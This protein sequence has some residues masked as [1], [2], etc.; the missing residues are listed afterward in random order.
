[1]VSRGHAGNAKPNKRKPD[2]YQSMKRRGVY[3][4][5]AEMPFVD[6]LAA[7]ILDIAENDPE[8]LVQIK[9]LLPTRRSCRALS[10]AFLRLLDG[11]AALLP[12]MTPLG[13][14]DSDEIMMGEFSQTIFNDKTEAEEIF[15][16]PPA[17]DQTRRIL[18][19]ARL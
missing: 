9:V 11:K 10:D 6:S 17:I 14:V 1:M 4:I 13:D 16:F 19:L 7:G 5:P 15:S 12:Q 3:N 2:G 18:L 8:Q